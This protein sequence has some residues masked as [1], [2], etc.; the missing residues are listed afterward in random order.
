MPAVS[1]R[2][3]FCPC[4]SKSMLMA[5]RV[6]PGSSKAITR[7]SPRI[8]FTSV[9]LPTLGRPTKATLIT[10]GR[11][12]SALVSTGVSS[13]VPSTPVARSSA[14]SM[15]GRTFSPCAAEIATGSPRPSSWNSA[16]VRSGAR[17]SALFTA[18]ITGRP[19]LRRRSAIT[20]SW[21]VRPSRASTMNSTIS[22][23]AIAW[24]VCRAM[25]WRIPLVAL[26]S[27]PPV[28]TTK[29]VRSPSRARP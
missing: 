13:S 2:V 16:T 26:G 4:R 9:D 18:R 25:A 29:Y 20:L 8:V 22:A 14:C 23:S 27:K 15:S 5:S 24:R 10:S 3:Y 28:S 11:S 21:G 12:R 1:M 6:V 19:A 17:P 7:S